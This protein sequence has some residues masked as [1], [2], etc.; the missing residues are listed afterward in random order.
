MLNP[1]EIR[2]STAKP[3]LEFTTKNGINYYVY[4]ADES[5]IG[6]GKVYS[7]GFEPLGYP[8]DRQ[9]PP[10][11]RVGSTI[12]KI[13]ESYFNTK[14]NIIV[15]IAF[16]D[17]PWRLRLFNCW[18]NRYKNHLSCPRIEKDEVTFV[19]DTSSSISISAVYKETYSVE[20]KSLLVGDDISKS[21]DDPKPND[22]VTDVFD[23]AS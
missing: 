6:K 14:E 12:A 9:F 1:Y 20:A 7:F 2:P 13:L 4:F 10:D 21:W 23:S 17:D 16:Q 5:W 8:M 3:G 19:Y 18:F 11:I 15:Y 22:R